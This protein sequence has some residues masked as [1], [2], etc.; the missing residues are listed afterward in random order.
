MLKALRFKK[1]EDEV[2]S[3]RGNEIIV[4][5]KATGWSRNK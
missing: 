4:D 5:F 2:K 1:I 3:Y